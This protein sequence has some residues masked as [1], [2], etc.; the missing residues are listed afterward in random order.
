MDPATAAAREE[1]EG[2]EISLDEEGLDELDEKAGRPKGEGGDATTEGA[3]IG[4]GP[5]AGG[6]GVPVA[7][8]CDAGTHGMVLLSQFL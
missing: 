7:F 2:S 5:A 4:E 3:G 8:L 1:S 6:A